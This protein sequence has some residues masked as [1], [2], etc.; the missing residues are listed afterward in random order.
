MKKSEQTPARTNLHKVVEQKYWTDDDQ[1]LRN[2]EADQEESRS[3]LEKTNE[4]SAEKDNETLKSGIITAAYRMVRGMV[5]SIVSMSLLN[6]LTIRP[7]GVMSK[8]CMGDFMMR[9]NN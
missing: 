9:S 5:V 3:H 6:R 7:R 4:P 8:K 1:K 2:L